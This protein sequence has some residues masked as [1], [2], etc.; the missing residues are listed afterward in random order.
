M[1]TISHLLRMQLQFLSS[2]KEH[3]MPRLRNEAGLR[4]MKENPISLADV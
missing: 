2:D 3:W 1:L 4:E